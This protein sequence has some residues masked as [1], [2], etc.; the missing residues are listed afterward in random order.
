M[1]VVSFHLLVLL[2][3]LTIQITSQLLPLLTTP[4]GI[5]VEGDIDDDRL[6][7]SSEK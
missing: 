2:F 4:A 7:L 3:L 1:M 5:Q 6:R